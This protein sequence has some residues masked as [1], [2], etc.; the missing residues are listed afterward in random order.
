MNFIKKISIE[1]ELSE[2]EYKLERLYALAQLKVELENKQGNVLSKLWNQYQYN[3]VLT[4]FQ[5]LEKNRKLFEDKIEEIK[6][7]L[8]IYE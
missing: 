6:E 5:V 1:K 3:H 4:E 8:K 7:E 2:L